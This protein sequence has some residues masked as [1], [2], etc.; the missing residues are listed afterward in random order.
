MLFTW[1]DS[2][3]R[4]TRRAG[5]EEGNYPTC[6][7]RKLESGMIEGLGEER[8]TAEQMSVYWRGRGGRGRNTDR[9]EMEREEEEAWWIIIVEV[10]SGVE[11]ITRVAG[12]QTSVDRQNCTGEEKRAR[13][14]RNIK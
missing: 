10:V 2:D 8:R 1:R 13:R 12:Q 11:R 5:R 14:E 6:E 4:L 7:R 9:K 3:N